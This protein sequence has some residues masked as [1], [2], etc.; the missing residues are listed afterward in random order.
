MAR[1]GSDKTISRLQERAEAVRVAHAERD[2]AFAE[3]I[4]RRDEGDPRTRRWRDAI[5]R[6][7]VALDLAYPGTLREVEEGERAIGTMHV[8]DILEYL[9]ADPMHFRSGYIKQRLL[10]E[11]KKRDLEPAHVRLL[12]DVVLHVVRSRSCRE[13][14]DYCRAAA[15]V[16]DTRLRLALEEIVASGSA[17]AR[18]RGRWLIGALDRAVSTR[19]GEAKQRTAR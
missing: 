12:Q 16:D 9:A 11:I 2:A 4:N 1:R 6:F 19:A 5:Q 18:Q 13:F 10:R 15:R 17:D 14:R 8:A 3:V 7:R